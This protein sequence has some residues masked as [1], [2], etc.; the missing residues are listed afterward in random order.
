MNSEDS[1]L[2]ELESDLERRNR[3]ARYR[4]LAIVALAVLALIFGMVC[5][6]LAVDNERLA[7]ANAA[8]G[9]TQQ[10]E[11]Q[12]L[13]EEFDAACKSA[14]FAQSAA[15]SNIC[16]K[17][18][19][20]ASESPHPL[21]GAKGEPGRDGAP[22]RDGV[23]GADGLPGKDG[24][25]GKDGAAGAAGRDGLPGADGLPGQ[26]GA[27]GVDGKDGAPGADSTVPGPPGAT[28]PQGP[29][30]EPGRGISS[31]V[32]NDDGRWIITY[33]D[34]GVQDAGQCRSPIIG[35]RP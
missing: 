28:G 14:D 26:P 12:S 16:R 34:G 8:F 9:K 25:P 32:C 22:G 31:T 10:K 3:A 7:S 17:A 20:V 4:N 21:P 2:Q 29:Q 23:N 33:T 30:G 5:L 18:A 11:K 19:Q 13:A 24:Q 35:V 15:G 27:D 6:F 1:E